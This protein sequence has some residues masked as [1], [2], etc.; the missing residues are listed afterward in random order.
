MHCC[1]HIWCLLRAS[2]KNKMLCFKA[3]VKSTSK[4]K[5]AKWCSV[6]CYFV[7]FA[8]RR[9]LYIHFVYYIHS[10]LSLC[11]SI[12]ELR[13]RSHLTAAQCLRLHLGTQW[14]VPN[15]RAIH[16]GLCVATRGYKIAPVHKWFTTLLMLV[17]CNLVWF[18]RMYIWY[19][20][21]QAAH[22]LNNYL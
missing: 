9:V 2:T 1:L 6:C 21:L 22:N 11:I 19:S 4:N 7:P 18:P 15:F 12:V 16:H 14:L 10:S 8:L 5:R 20:S 13:S 17:L 3:M